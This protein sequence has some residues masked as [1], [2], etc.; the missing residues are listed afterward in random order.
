MIH[1]KLLL[2]CIAIICITTVSN[3][4]MNSYGMRLGANYSSVNG[5][6]IPEEFDDSRIGIAVGFF[7]EITLK[8][9]L[10]FQPEL[11]YS[12]Q[13]NK[14]EDF[15]IDYIQ[16]PMIFKY[17]VHRF[18]NVQLGPQVGLK[19]WEWEDSNN[20]KTFDFAAVAGLGI[21]ITKNIFVDLR[22]AYG[23]S[24]IVDEDNFASINDGKNR[25]IQLSIG[26]KI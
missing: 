17:N 11:Q 24:N 2:L 12:A 1:N 16:A 7:A 23:L 26:Y 15:R 19:I 9:N 14:E 3:A 20:Y 5:D 10:L 18:L 25:N 21:T 4:Q 22:Y 13:G 6:D 8:K